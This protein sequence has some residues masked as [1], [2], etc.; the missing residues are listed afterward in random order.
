MKVSVDGRRTLEG[1]ELLEAG[2]VQAIGLTMRA[3]VKDAEKAARGTV[4]W[5]DRTGG[6]RETIK[7]EWRGIGAGGFVKAG[8]ASAFLENGTRAHVIRGNPILR[9]VVNGQVLFRR[10]VRHPGTKPRPFMREARNIGELSVL[11]HAQ[12]F[13]GAAIA[14]SR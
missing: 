9:F 4:L 11:F 2:V 1:L 12:A 8:G 10:M 7:G 14:R 5:K 6:T 3:A 13:L